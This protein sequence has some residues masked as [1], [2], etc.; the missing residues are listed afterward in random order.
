MSVNKD[1][2]MPFIDAKSAQFHELETALDEETCSLNTSER[3]METSRASGPSA[4]PPGGRVMPTTIFPYKQPHPL[5]AIFAPKSVAVVGATEKAGSVGR[6]LLWNLIS[7]PFGG[8]VFPIN[9]TRAN[10]LGIKAYPTVAA[11]PEPVDL[12]VIATPAPT[13]PALLTECAEVGVKGAIILSAGFK[14]AGAAGAELEGHIL[15]QARWGGAAHHWAQQ[16]R[17]DEPAERP[18][19]LLCQHDGSARPRRLHQSE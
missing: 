4:D 14:Q 8:T 7:H 3:L 16:P 17:G 5:D 10:V 18:Q 11:L 9:P 13:V 19:C 1:E 2:A 6:A 15:E 12:V